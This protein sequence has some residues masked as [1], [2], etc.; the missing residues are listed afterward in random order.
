MTYLL[1]NSN[2]KYMWDIIKIVQQTVMEM[3]ML[4]EHLFY[5][6]RLE[7]LSLEK[8]QGRFLCKG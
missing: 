4:L 8:A 1:M 7:L 2:F 5:E 3:I 6:E